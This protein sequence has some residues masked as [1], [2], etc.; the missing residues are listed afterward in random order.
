[1]NH[2]NQVGSL[3]ECGVSDNIIVLRKKSLKFRIKFKILMNSF[4]FYSNYFSN[5]MI[6]ITVLSIGELGGIWAH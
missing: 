6:F 1:M 3:K 5:Y 4:N 2:N